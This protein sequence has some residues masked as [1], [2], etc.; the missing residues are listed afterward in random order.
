MAFITVLVG[1]L[2][3]G[4]VALLLLNTIAA[5]DAFKIHTLRARAAALADTEQALSLQLQTSS[6]PGSLA[7]AAA[8]LGMVPAG[9][10]A[11]L[12]LS[13]GRIL[14]VLTA[15]VPPAPPPAPPP[16]TASP[17]PRS[18]AAPPAAKAKSPV[19][20]PHPAKS[21]AAASGR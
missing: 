2:G 16:P 3:G 1:V 4:L 11:F 13:G 19:V 6:A 5:Q 21:P 20:H 10:P 9:P 7:A 17:A 12:P 18:K 14:A 8:R 15:A